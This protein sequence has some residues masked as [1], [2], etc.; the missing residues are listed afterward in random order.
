MGR[1]DNF[2]IR[3]CNV[4]GLGFQPWAEISASECGVN[5]KIVQ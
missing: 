2:N 4:Y 3:G 1:I 5:S